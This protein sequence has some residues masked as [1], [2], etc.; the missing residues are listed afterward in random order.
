MGTEVFSVLHL[1]LFLNEF[2]A[3]SYKQNSRS[4]ILKSD[5]K[6]FIL[7]KKKLTVQD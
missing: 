7:G 3:V 4:Q 5:E 1:I 2:Y 6:K